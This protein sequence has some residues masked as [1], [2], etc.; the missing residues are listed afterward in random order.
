[1]KNKLLEINW[2]FNGLDPRP[3]RH[4]LHL[5]PATM[6]ASCVSSLLDIFNPS[7]VLDP[8]GGSGTVALECVKR[9]IPV[10]TNDL[11]PLARLIIKAKLL[12]YNN[13]FNDVVNSV[14][15]KVICSKKETNDI[16][17]FIMNKFP[18]TE[19]GQ[20]IREDDD[21]VFNELKNIGFT[22]NKF[23]NISYWFQP[24]TIVELETI[25]KILPDHCFFYMCFSELIRIVSNRRSGEFKLFRKPVDKLIKSINN[26][27]DEFIKIVRRSWE[28]VKNTNLRG[29]DYYILSDDAR[30]LKSIPDN[31]FDLMI[32]SPPYGDSKTTVA[33]GQF[34]RL[35]IQWMPFLGKESPNSIDDILLGGSKVNHANLDIFGRIKNSLYLIEE[36]DKKRHK[37]VEIFFIDLYQSFISIDKKCKNSGYQVWIVGNRTVKEINIP[38]DDFIIDVGIKHG[39]DHVVTLYRNIPYKSMP[40]KNSPTNKIGKTVKTINNES[41]VVLQKK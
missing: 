36:I 41:I 4:S 5:Y 13:D 8:F 22:Y 15:D 34:S 39:Y 7:C 2:T 24:E 30:E 12:T 25:K 32:T 37:E 16:I 20:K 9:Q 35:S 11:N 26:T 27:F 6:H 28:I 10:Y 18:L 38:L 31:I 33:Y 17:N 23:K 21:Y 3:D 14:I 1:M 40:N 19:D 29:K